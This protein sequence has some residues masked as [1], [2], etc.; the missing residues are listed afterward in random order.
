MDFDVSK[1]IDGAMFEI[2]NI[3]KDGLDYASYENQ[4]IDV[5]AGL[6]DV[7]RLIARGELV[8]EPPQRSSFGALLEKI[9]EGLIELDNMRGRRANLC[10][11]SP[12]FIC[13]SP[14]L[15]QPNC[16]YFE[17]S[18]FTVNSS[19]GRRGEQCV[20]RDIDTGNC[21]CQ[22]AQIEKFKD[23]SKK[24]AVPRP[25]TN[26]SLEIIK[27]AAKVLEKQNTESKP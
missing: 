21:L 20:Y 27:A 3:E 18:I 13:S 8:L 24:I 4:V 22:K 17:G 26:E 11:L 16:K 25:S 9:Y 14:P 10:N 19:D 5:M 1:K 23:V 15:S 7:F 2:S 6:V 12:K